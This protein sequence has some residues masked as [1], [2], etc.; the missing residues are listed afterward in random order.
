[1][2]FARLQGA[3]GRVLTIIDDASP[4]AA[5]FDTKQCG[6]NRTLVAAY[7]FTASS[8]TMADAVRGSPFS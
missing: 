8:T 6:A 3:H 2:F 1:M 4:A 5:T 7:G